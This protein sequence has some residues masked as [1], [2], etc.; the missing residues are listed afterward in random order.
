MQHDASLR[1]RKTWLSAE[2]EENEAGLYYISILS[3]RGSS[4]KN[5][6]RTIEAAIEVRSVLC[7]LCETTVIIFSLDGLLFLGQ[8]VQYSFLFLNI[9]PVDL[10]QTKFLAFFFFP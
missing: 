10:F 3:K 5:K 4:M 2:T 7:F 6:T 1:N 9:F 8:S